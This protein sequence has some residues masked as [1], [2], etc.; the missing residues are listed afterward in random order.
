[1]ILHHVFDS[2]INA[3]R[4]HRLMRLRTLL[5]SQHGAIRLSTYFE[6]ALCCESAELCPYFLNLLLSWIRGAQSV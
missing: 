4:L 5:I 2:Q 3:R 6:M 1:M